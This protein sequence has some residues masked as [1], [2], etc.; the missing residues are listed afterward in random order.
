MSFN[1]IDIG[2]GSIENRIITIP[3]E[4]PAV[5]AGA[6][7]PELQAGELQPAELQAA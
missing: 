5:P 4:H 7:V 1:L 3:E 6:S 2:P